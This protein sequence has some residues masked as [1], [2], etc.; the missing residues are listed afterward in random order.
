M[1]SYYMEKEEIDS[2]EGDWNQDEDEYEDMIEEENDYGRQT[3]YEEYVS[4]S[5][6]GEEP[7]GEELE[8][9]PPDCYPSSQR[10]EPYTYMPQATTKWSQPS[11]GYY[12]D[13]Y[14]EDCHKEGPEAY[15]RW[16]AALMD[17]FE[18]YHVPEK[19]KTSYAEDALTGGAYDLWDDIETTRIHFKDLAYSWKEMRKLMYGE[20]VKNAS[21]QAHHNDKGV[22]PTNS[23]RQ[24]QQKSSSKVV[25]KNAFPLP[26]PIKVFPNTL[27]KKSEAKKP[28]QVKEIQQ[29]SIITSLCEPQGK[30]N[31]GTM[32][33]CN[34]QGDV[35]S[36]EIVVS[37]EQHNQ[38]IMESVLLTPTK[39]YARRVLD[40]ILVKEEPPDSPQHIKIQGELH[41]EIMSGIG[42]F[43]KKDTNLSQ[44]QEHVFKCHIIIKD[45][46]PDSSQHS[47]TNQSRG[48]Y[49]NSQKRMKPNLF[50][51]G[52]G[53]TVL[54]SKL[55]EEGGYDVDIG[56]KPDPELTR[57]AGSILNQTKPDQ[58]GEFWRKPSSD[59][60]TGLG[61]EIYKEIYPK[62]SNDSA[63]IINHHAELKLVH[64]D[65]PGAH[66]T[67][68]HRPDQDFSRP[69]L[70]IHHQVTYF[71][72]FGRDGIKNYR[73]NKLERQ[74][75]PSGSSQLQYHRPII[76][77]L[78]KI[79]C[80][81]KS[82]C[83]CVIVESIANSI[84]IS[85]NAH[86]RV[87]A[88]QLLTSCDQ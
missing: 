66:K 16:E 83:S 74:E 31:Q 63:G 23:K 69:I 22:T 17:W 38:G 29:N 55:F 84:S 86:F 73:T 10:A 14:E 82:S 9:E 81:I 62:K 65:S 32:V 57:P 60:A 15:L 45:K 87:K 41:G 50:S 58:K 44:H 27:S 6:C 61:L 26:E 42:D 54:K 4:S 85:T 24:N 3:W 8:P 11:L 21:A 88:C 7:D 13:E 47:P 12:E 52:A 1:A 39:G 20:F 5:D 80:G 51:L 18:R 59:Q 76:I 72:T 56:T 34:Y 2:Y 68:I 75:D 70:N 40:T 37:S 28:V 64:N 67:Q 53:E 71:K 77:D 79:A 19:K 36:K 78:I 48:N 30:T 49:L 35:P 25:N 33:K 43:T 46:P